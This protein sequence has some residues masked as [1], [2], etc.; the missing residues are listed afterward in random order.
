MLAG[1]VM[2]IVPNG[3]GFIGGHDYCLTRDPKEVDVEKVAGDAVEDALRSVGA[4]PLASGSY[5]V[6]IKAGCMSSL[7]STFSG[8]F[9]AE[10][11]QKGLS[12]LQGREGDVVAASCVTLIDDPLLA[13]GYASRPFDD[14][15]V[16]SRT[17]EVISQGKLVT[18][19][20]NLKTA[21]KAGVESTGNAAKASVSSPVTVAP[22]NFY[23]KP[24]DCTLADLEE[25]MG[26]GLVITDVSG[27][28]AGANATSG[29][30]SLICEGYAVKDG[31][32]ER[33]MEQMTISGNFYQ[34]LLGVQ[35]VA[36][37]LRF[38]SSCIASPSVRVANM[39]LAGK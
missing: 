8:I 23:I 30:F 7:L 4:A 13:D 5:P 9:S 16:P 35:E 33:A 26:E 17:K 2:P 11:A 39:P 3:Q 12:Q 19:L 20:H 24:G 28:H 6:I 21:A 25:K 18:L 14:E 29:D 1:M 15:G 38:G 27:L 36:N 34:L 10:N 37:D 32:F 31:K 22:S